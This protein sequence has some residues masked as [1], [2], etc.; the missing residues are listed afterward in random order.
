MRLIDADALP[1][2]HMEIIDAETEKEYVF[3]L[4]PVEIVNSA[5]TID[6]VPVVRCAECKYSIDSWACTEKPC[7]C[8]RSMYG[9]NHKP[10]HFCSYGERR[11]DD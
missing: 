7:L 8:T 5:P 11:S 4:V 6:A 1:N 3:N 10:D 9:G 2:Y